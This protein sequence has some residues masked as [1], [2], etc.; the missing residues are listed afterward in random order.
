[1]ALSSSIGGTQDPQNGPVL[2]AK[3]MFKGQGAWGSRRQVRIRA[4]LWGGYSSDLSLILVARGH[5]QQELP[6]FYVVEEDSW[7]VAL[8]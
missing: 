2:K 6:D 8:S 5:S 7:E 1:M 4:L 3:K